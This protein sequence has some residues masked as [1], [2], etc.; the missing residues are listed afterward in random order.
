M[1]SNKPPAGQR[2][3][4]L[5]S[6]LH[7]NVNNLNNF[8][9]KSNR[10]GSEK[11]KTHSSNSQHRRR[12]RTKLNPPTQSAR[13]VFALTWMQKKN[14]T[15]QNAKN[16]LSWIKISRKNEKLQTKL[17]QIFGVTMPHINVVEWIFAQLWVLDHWISTQTK[18]PNKTSEA[19]H[20]KKAAK[21]L[22]QLP[23]TNNRL[24][25]GKGGGGRWRRRMKKRKEQKTCEW[26]SIKLLE[27]S[28]SKRLALCRKCRTATGHFRL[29]WQAIE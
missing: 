22:G 9:I 3:N 17:W 21:M 2:S 15:N 6:F 4:P 26:N 7:T 16:S 25:E 14:K 19:W 23:K 29:L 11:W 13:F 5:S 20:E 8:V 10:T 27:E 28:F 24:R 18:P 1:I 12:Q